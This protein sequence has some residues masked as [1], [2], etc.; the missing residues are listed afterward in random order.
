M[1][2]CICKNSENVKCHMLKLK[3]AKEK[4]LATI[5]QARR[6]HASPKNKKK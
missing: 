2:N 1:K 5:I 3:I 4:L 6:F